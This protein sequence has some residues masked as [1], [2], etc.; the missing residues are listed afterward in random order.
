MCDVLMFVPRS[1]NLPIF[2]FFRFRQIPRGP[3]I[4]GTAVPFRATKFGCF[5]RQ[6]TPSEIGSNQRS[7]RNRRIRLNVRSSLSISIPDVSDPIRYSRLRMISD[8]G[9]FSPCTQRRVKWLSGD[10]VGSSSNV[11]IPIFSISFFFFFSQSF[12]LFPLI[13]AQI[14]TLSLLDR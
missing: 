14:S 3:P 11:F 6:K 5:I 8:P 7:Q 4:S 12:S 13:H 1:A 2:P 9:F 10:R